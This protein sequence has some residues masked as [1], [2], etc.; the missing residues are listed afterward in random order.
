[1]KVVVRTKK[2]ILTKALISLLCASKGHGGMLGK[3]GSHLSGYDLPWSRAPIP[4]PSMGKEVA[5]I[6]RVH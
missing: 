2:I 5:T 4:L 1:M 3:D 6:D